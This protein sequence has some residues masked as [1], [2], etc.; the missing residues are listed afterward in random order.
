[1]QPGRVTVQLRRVALTNAPQ[2]ATGGW[3]GTTFTPAE[4]VRTK[5]GGDV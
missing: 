3:Q 2:E 4:I 1:M 5:G